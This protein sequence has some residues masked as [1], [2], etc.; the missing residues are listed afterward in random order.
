MLV[1]YD[2]SK[3]T[4]LVPGYN[5]RQQRFYSRGHLTPNSDFG[6]NAEREFT[7]VNTN[8]APQWQAFNSKNWVVVENAVTTY[9]NRRRL[10]VFTGT[11]KNGK[12]FNLSVRVWINFE[13]VL[14]Q[15]PN[16]SFLNIDY[17]S[18]WSIYYFFV[19]V[20]LHFII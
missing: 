18:H 19:L 4:K 8:V 14:L 6:T 3:Q 10:Y 13:Q 5:Q 2:P 7:M 12:A 1:D 15:F 17:F 9:S 11:G 20:C 16:V